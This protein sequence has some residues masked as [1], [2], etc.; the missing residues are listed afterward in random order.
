MLLNETDINSQNHWS[1]S[2]DFSIWASLWAL[3]IFEWHLLLF[4]VIGMYQGIEIG[5]PG[6]KLQRSEM[7]SW[8]R[9]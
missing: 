8:S 5:H 7:F 6:A 3:E 9:I 1:D 2:F 4:A